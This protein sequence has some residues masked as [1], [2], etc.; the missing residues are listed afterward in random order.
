MSRR[1]FATG[2]CIDVRRAAELLAI[3]T[4]ALGGC[5]RSDTSTAPSRAV[6]PPPPV[7][8]VTCAVAPVLPPHETAHIHAVRR[9]DDGTVLAVG[10]GGLVLSGPAE[11]PLGPL[12]SPTERDLYGLDVRMGPG[13]PELVAVGA[14]GTWIH[15][16]PDALTAKAGDG[17]D[18]RDVAF[19]PDGSALAVGLAGAVLRAP[20]GSV[21]T[22]AG[23]PDRLRAVD[24]GADGTV[25]AAGDIG[26]LAVRGAAGEWRD[27]EQDT[28]WNFRGVRVLASESAL[29]VGDE[30]GVLAWTAAGW[31]IVDSGTDEYLAAVDG[32]DV[33]RLFVATRSGRVLRRDEGVFLKEGLGAPVA[34]AAIDASVPGSELGVGPGGA[35]VGRTDDAWWPLRPWPW[36]ARGGV[37]AAD[38]RAVL[39]GAMGRV[40]LVSADGAVEHRPVRTRH[41]LEA[42]AFAGERLVV[43]GAAGAAFRWTGSEWSAERTGVETRLEDI[44]AVGDGTLVAVGGGGAALVRDA[45]GAWTAETTGTDRDLHAVAMD[46]GEAW[47]VGAGGVVARRG[48]GW[49]V[50]AGPDGYDLRGVAVD[51]AGRLFVG[52]D[53]GG[54]YVRGED[55]WRPVPGRVATP[56]RSVLRDGSRV[57]FAGASGRVGAAEADG[58]VRWRLEPA[59]AAHRWEA[60]LPLTGGKALLVDGAGALRLAGPCEEGE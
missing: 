33:E 53:S 6:R 59:Q 8:T 13:G 51:A 56:I 5:R 58:V 36:L 31:G 16:A 15:G 42:A 9:L 34:L 4:L 17:F 45:G 28:L 22:E 11:G 47:A 20:D 27:A 25:V 3:V 29:V 39:V 23:A 60:A 10:A 32:P 14:G 48:D 50:V 19:L 30:G 38:G 46:G 37:V 44:V 55:G 18:L 26:R 49:T 57:L 43:V 7:P 52:G 54:P 2:W 41:T 1:V 21:A 40:V 24:V 12:P 35:V